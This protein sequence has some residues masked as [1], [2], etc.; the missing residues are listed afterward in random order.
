MM[1]VKKKVRKSVS[2]RFKVTKTGKVLFAHQYASHKKLHKSKSRI[3]RQKEPGQ[4]EGEFAKK[5]KQMLGYA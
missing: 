2:K 1:K 3:R 4:L 5:I